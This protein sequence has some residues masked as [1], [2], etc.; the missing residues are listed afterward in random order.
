MEFLTGTAGVLMA[1][2]TGC[3]GFRSCVTDQIGPGS[4]AKKG[5]IIDLGNGTVAIPGLKDLHTHPGIWSLME[6]LQ[7]INLKKCKSVSDVVEEL[8]KYRDRKVIVADGLNTNLIPKLTNADL[9][10]VS[11]E[12]PVF[13]FDPSYHGG[14]L[15]TKATKEVIAAAAPYK[16]TL[17]GTLDEDGHWTEQY[18]YIC[19]GVAGK[20]IGEETLTEF[21]SGWIN[22]QLQKGITE[23]NDMDIL[24]IDLL[25]ALV[26]ACEIWKGKT[27]GLPFPVTKVYGPPSVIVELQKDRELLKKANDYFG[28]IGIKFYADGSIGSHTAALK[29]PFDDTGGYGVIVD[30]MDS[31]REFLK[32]C[33][34]CE[35][36]GAAV[37]A[38]GDK[39]IEHAFEIANLMD[40]A[41]GLR[42]RIEH[43]EISGNVAILET[44]KRLVYNE[45]MLEGVSVQP[46]FN[47]DIG[48]YKGRLGARVN[49]INPIAE[50]IAAGIPL[51]FGTDGMPQS[52]MK[53]LNEAVAHPVIQHR[54]DLETALRI[55]STKGMW[56]AG[57]ELKA[58]SFIIADA[59]LIADLRKGG[60]KG[61]DL[62]KKIKKVVYHGHDAATLLK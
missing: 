3:L 61:E 29:E 27:G 36:T 28:G 2:K 26:N 32:M 43:F 48:E 16:K 7:V 18:T 47:W 39:G 34:G 14:Y 62:E 44:A 56:A 22:K 17:K 46:V 8:K 59:S 21:I 11:T 4:F 24:S 53:A 35:L 40:A 57:E 12:V 38:I 1:A 58:D 13:V 37:H 51:N 31:I 5:P 25:R 20:T 55:A 45:R 50:I 52:M 49:L 41:R 30:T 9:D 54:I 60:Q 6:G 23:I 10:Q 33:G 42:T 19:L 15:N